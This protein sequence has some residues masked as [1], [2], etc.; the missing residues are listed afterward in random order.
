MHPPGV[1]DEPDQ[2]FLPR[3]AVPGVTQHY[4][5]PRIEVEGAQDAVLVVAA[6]S[7]EAVHGHHERDVPVFEVVHRREAVR[8]APGVREDYGAER[9]CASSS[10]RNQN[11]S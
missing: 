5:C 7:R 8:Q 2:H 10:Q 9:P 4:R 1:L 6:C 11:R 3:V